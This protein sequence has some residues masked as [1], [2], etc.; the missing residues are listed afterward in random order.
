VVVLH[1]NVV[2]L[3]HT[4]S[5]MESLWRGRIRTAVFNPESDNIDEPIDILFATYTSAL[6]A[7]D[8]IVSCLRKASFC[9]LDE[10]HTQSEDQEVFCAR[11]RHSW[12]QR[13]PKKRPKIAVMT[14]YA[15]SGTYCIYGEDPFGGCR[16]SEPRPIRFDRLRDDL[17]PVEPKMILAPSSKN[18]LNVEIFCRY[19]LGLSWRME[20]GTRGIIFAPL[21]QSRQ[22][23]FNIISDRASSRVMMVDPEDE[24]DVEAFE[25]A[26]TSGVTVVAIMKPYFGAR[27]IR[28]ASWVV[29]PG[30]FEDAFFDPD[31][32]KEVLEWRELAIDWINFRLRMPRQDLK[33]LPD[34]LSQPQTLIRSSPHGT[35]CGQAGIC[36]TTPSS[37][38][39]ST[40]KVDRSKLGK[41][42]GYVSRTASTSRPRLP[43]S[44]SGLAS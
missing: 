26:D 17:S 24:A 33:L 38:S 42:V 15:E 11:L 7:S 22:T 23:L 35:R 36:S 20:I 8:R 12:K 6:I 39:P 4:R 43:G 14:T 28:N 3:N 34:A 21:R 41:T 9:V 25:T 30:N 1:P 31:L 19:A 5:K 44:F 16:I 18:C 32:G 27:T 2:S 37:S 29:C 13:T 40:P 10:V